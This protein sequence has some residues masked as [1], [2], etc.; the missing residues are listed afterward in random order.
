MERLIEAVGELRDEVRVLREAIDEFREL[1]DW[2]VRNAAPHDDVPRHIVHVT[3]MPADP[4]APDFGERVNRFTAKDLPGDP[5]VAA[6][7]SPPAAAAPATA[8]APPPVP[9]PPA[10]APTALPAEP[11]S[12]LAP[13]PASAAPQAAQGAPAPAER[14]A[15]R[16]R[17]PLWKRLYARPHLIEVVR[18]LGYGEL[19]LDQVQQALTRL[20][21]QYGAEKIDEA[22]EILHIDRSKSLPTVRLT[23][24][25]KKV[26][27]S[28]LGLP[29]TSPHA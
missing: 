14:T 12:P 13:S 18:L 9:K 17:Q 19:P 15:R 25:V 16:R 7:A 28:L 1:Y 11:T 5:P 24:A 10:T 23:E 6:P 20:T 2:A 29:P 3:S 4:L 8:T 22:Q 27:V 26:A 21:A